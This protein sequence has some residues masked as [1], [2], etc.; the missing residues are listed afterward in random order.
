M[1]L[2]KKAEDLH[3]KLMHELKIG[4]FL[5]EKHHHDSYKDIRKDIKRITE[6]VKTAEELDIALDTALSDEVN[7]YTL[8]LLSERNLR[9][10][11]DLYEDSITTCD[12]DKVNKL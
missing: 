10:Q 2:K 8:R 11:R 7:G 4:N 9:K 12:K 1:K 3:L 5:K 6:M